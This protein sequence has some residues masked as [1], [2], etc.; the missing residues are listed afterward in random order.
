MET[1]DKHE[2]MIRRK[3]DGEG[4][5]ISSIKFLIFSR[6][7]K[8]IVCFNSSEKFSSSLLLR[9]LICFCCKDESIDFLATW[10][11]VFRFLSNRKSIP[12]ITCCIFFLTF[13]CFCLLT[14][15]DFF[16]FCTKGKFLH[17]V[18]DCWLFTFAFLWFRLNL[19][20]C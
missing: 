15:Y 4:E 9:L 20:R 2:T 7:H 16:L 13:K 3:K 1:S 8:F 18:T 10:L 14:T 17:H 5:R 11:F 6:F 12:L 19:F